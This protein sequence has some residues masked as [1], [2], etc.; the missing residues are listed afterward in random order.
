M[1]LNPD[2]NM[3]VSR[4]AAGGL[5]VGLNGRAPVGSVGGPGGIRGSGGLV[6]LG[7]DRHG[8]E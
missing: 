4:V 5:G 3:M 7:I 6:G 1:R 2:G 8:K